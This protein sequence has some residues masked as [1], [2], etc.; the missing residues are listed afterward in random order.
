MA[1]LAINGQQPNGQVTPQGQ[2]PGGVPQFNPQAPI[3][4]V[5]QDVMALNPAAPAPTQQIGPN[6][7]PE[8]HQPGAHVVD[9]NNPQLQNPEAFGNQ[10]NEALAQQQAQHQAQLSQINSQFNQQIGSLQQQNQQISQQLQT[11]SS[12]TPTDRELDPFEVNALDEDERANLEGLLPGLDKRARANAEVVAREVKAEMKQLM[13]QQAQRYQQQIE[14]LNAQLNINKAAVEQNFD[15]LLSNTAGSHGLDINQLANDPEWNKLLASPTSIADPTP[16]HEVVSKA[17]ANRQ[18]GPI[19]SILSHFAQNRQVPTSN[20]SGL[21]T[22]S[23]AREQQPNPAEEQMTDLTNKR[24]AVYQKMSDLREQVDR[25]ELSA[26][27]FR[28]A[29]EQLMQYDGQIM[30]QIE[31]LQQNQQTAA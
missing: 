21:P 29:S 31:A 16:L 12:N 6:G 22:G 23:Q 24:Q 4:P 8:W 19:S 9:A 26:D 7:N 17:V 15:T 2:Q 18:I 5:M 28:Q 3:D 10:L 1:H 25:R 13:D 27:Q 11:L 20:L 30:Q 14:G